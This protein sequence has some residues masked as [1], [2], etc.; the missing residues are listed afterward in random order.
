MFSCNAISLTDY[1]REC[2][3]LISHF[4]AAQNFTGIMKPEDV[5]K[6]MQQYQLDCKTAFS[7]L[8][9]IGIPHSG[10]SGDAKSVAETVQHF[11]TL[12]DSLKLQMVAVDEI[13]PLLADLV[14]S[15]NRSLVPFS[16]QDR[17]H[18]WLSSLNQMKASEE[19]NPEQIRQM[20]HD[21]E[22]AYN[23]FHKNL[24]Q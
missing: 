11:I 2:A 19:L 1:K 12:M 15:A 17:L 14:D 5:K 10:G 4:K 3:L 18:N 13:Y 9:E 8:V 20:S 16:G 22:T 24:L 21:L 7:R 23:N 6:F